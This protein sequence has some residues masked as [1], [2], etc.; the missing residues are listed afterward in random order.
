MGL[1]PL[2]L[3]PLSLSL[4]G[5]ILLFTTP[6]IST[7]H[8]VC[9][10]TSLTILSQYLSLTHF[11]FIKFKIPYTQPQRNPYTHIDT[12]KHTCTHTHT[13]AHTYSHATVH[14]HTHSYIY[15][16]ARILTYIH[17]AHLCTH[18]HICAH[19]GTTTQE[20]K[21]LFLPCSPAGT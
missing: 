12:H 16:Y 15:I 9:L 8:A 20:E 5:F 18:T 11:F 2:E 3:S 1:K 21:H 13:Q 19:L 10:P 6:F 14:T 7:F 17:N 4:C